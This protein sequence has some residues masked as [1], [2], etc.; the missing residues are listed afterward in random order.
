MIL[1]D[2]WLEISEGK[3]HENF[4][5][6]HSK[7]CNHGKRGYVGGNPRYSGRQGFT[8]KDAQHSRAAV[9]QELQKELP[10]NPDSFN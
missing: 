5:G 2:E 3:D 8:P 1:F 7:D 9:K 4:R 10:L 6:K